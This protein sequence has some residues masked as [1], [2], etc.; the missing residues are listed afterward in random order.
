MG[1][2]SKKQ[3]KN[4][5]R[6]PLLLVL[7]AVLVMV[8]IWLV[9]LAD[10]SKAPL[11]EQ[12]II[13]ME[14][15]QHETSQNSQT[16]PQQPEYMELSDGLQILSVSKYAGMY[17]E[18]GTN[19]IVFDVLMIILENTSAQDLQLARIN[20]YYPDATAEFEVTNLPAGEK[21]VVLEKN[22]MAMMTDE[23]LSAEA[24]KVVF[25]PENMKLQEESI[26]ISGSNGSMEITNISGEDI[27]GDIYV[28][29]KN[30]AADLLYGGIT[31]RTSVKGGLKAGESVQVMVGH[32]SPDTSRILMVDC[33]E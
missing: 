12:E 27:S 2:Y 7:L 10:W 21:V 13:P 24:R 33:T 18:D 17:M 29:Y 19:E 16:E 9:N 22:R 11:L 8:L 31:Y 1:K 4:N 5:G 6:I 15:T 20:V 23:P 14:T 28:Y 26:R 32:Y 30:S 3:K 25:F